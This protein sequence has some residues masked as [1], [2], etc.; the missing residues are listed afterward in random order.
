MLVVARRMALSLLCVS[1]V[2]VC[3]STARAQDANACP[4]PRWHTEAWWQM[5]AQDPVGA[6]AQVECKRKLWPPYLRPV[7]PEQKTVPT[8]IMRNIIGPGLTCALTGGSCSIWCV[9]RRP[10]A[11][12]A[13]NDSLRLHANLPTPNKRADRSGQTAAQVDPQ[14]RAAQ[15]SHGRVT[16]KPKIRRSASSG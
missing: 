11:G 9:R 7:G 3:V 6:L 8:S 16:A 2:T 14:K 1:V 15:L 13:A 12:S 10:T 5:H 4:E